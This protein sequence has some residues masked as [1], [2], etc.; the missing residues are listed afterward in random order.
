MLKTTLLVKCADM[1][2]RPLPECHGGKGALDWTDVI[3]GE[4]TANTKLKFVHH[5]IL[6]PGVS[7]GEHRHDSGEEY[8]YIVDGHGVM[9]LD[10]EA[11]EVGSGD[12]TAVYA[13]G[14]HGLENTSNG[15]LRM[16]VIGVE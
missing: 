13:G 4:A 14:S 10:G 11:F 7:V 15:D 1:E 16:M 2:H 5:N 8:Y 6:A 9:T 3:S 12:I